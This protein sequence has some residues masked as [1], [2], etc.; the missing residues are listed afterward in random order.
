MRPDIY[1]VFL[2][3]FPAVFGAKLDPSRVG[4]QEPS[5]EDIHFFLFTRSSRVLFFITNTYI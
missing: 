1:I 5:A 3:T 2:L 4:G